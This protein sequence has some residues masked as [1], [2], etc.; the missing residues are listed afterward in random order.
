MGVRKFT[1]A[2]MMSALSPLCELH[3]GESHFCLTELE[4]LTIQGDALVL[5]RYTSPKTPLNLR[6]CKLCNDDIEDQEHFLFH[7]HALTGLRNNFFRRI[8]PLNSDFLWWCVNSIF[9]S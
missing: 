6:T 4:F 2:A 8:Q 1:I 5:A 7:C 3:S 9:P